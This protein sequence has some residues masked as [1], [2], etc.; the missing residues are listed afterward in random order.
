VRAKLPIL[1]HPPSLAMAGQEA[2]IGK[3]YRKQLWAEIGK[4]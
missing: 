3:V 4:N 1:A 2:Y